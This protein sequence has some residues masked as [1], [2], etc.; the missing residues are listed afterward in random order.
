MPKSKKTSKLGVRPLGK[1][2]IVAP[3]QLEAISSGGVMLPDSMR[4]KPDEAEVVAVGDHED[5]QL[6]IGDI[7]FLPSFAGSPIDVGGDIYRVIN[8]EDIIAAHV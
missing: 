2:V 3:V 7:V 1:R 4:E 5:I 6:G 8:Y